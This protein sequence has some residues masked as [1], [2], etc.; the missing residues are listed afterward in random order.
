MCVCVKCYV[1]MWVFLSIC[2]R[3]HVYFPHILSLVTS[4]SS[5]VFPANGIS[6]GLNIFGEIFVCVTV[7]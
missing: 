4:S 3:L 7:F 6:L 2:E 1:H 5:S